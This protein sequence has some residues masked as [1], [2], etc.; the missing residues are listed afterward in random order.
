MREITTLFSFL[1]TEIG[2]CY[3][4]AKSK[5]NLDSEVDLLINVEGS[6][7]VRLKQNEKYTEFVEDVPRIG[8]GAEWSLKVS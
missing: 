1:V 4:K 5:F 8:H 3:P 6:P 2:E 7:L